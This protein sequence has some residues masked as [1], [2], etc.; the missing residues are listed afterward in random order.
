MIA[1][2]HQ[3]LVLSPPLC[4]E[5]SLRN[6]SF[7]ADP[8]HLPHA[9]TD[10]QSDG[11]FGDEASLKPAEPLKPHEGD[12]CKWETFPWAVL[13]LGLDCEPPSPSNGC[14]I[15]GLPACPEHAAV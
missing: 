10:G 15:L 4:Q 13:P 5:Q 1:L 6:R 2:R 12:K 14:R 9:L 3:V 11:P 7:S 8:C